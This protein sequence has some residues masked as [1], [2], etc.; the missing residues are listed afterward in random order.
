MADLAPDVR[1]AR[2]AH[3]LTLIGEGVIDAGGIFLARDQTGLCGVQICVPLAGAGGL[4]WLPRTRSR[5]A[6][7]EEDL[8]Q[9]GLDWLRSR[10]TKVAQALLSP[11]DQSAVRPDCCGAVFDS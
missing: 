9:H 5:H 6:A 3:T 11:A 2:I 1:P 4:F 8:V 10:G 7:L